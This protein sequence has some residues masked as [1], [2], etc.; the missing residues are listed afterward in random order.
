MVEVRYSP[1]SRGVDVGDDPLSETEI[2]EPDPAFLNSQD[3]DENEILE[4]RGSSCFEYDEDSRDDDYGEEEERP[5]LED[6]LGVPRNVPQ[7]RQFLQPTGTPPM[8][9]NAAERCR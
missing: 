8:T 3:I 6:M 9:S 2:G 5:T 1:T 7:R 4:C